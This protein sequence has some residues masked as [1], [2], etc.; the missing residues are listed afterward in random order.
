M[1]TRVE[2]RANR[3]WPASIARADASPDARRSACQVP[4]LVKTTRPMSDMV[5]RLGWTWRR[6]RGRS[7][8]RGDGSR[9]T[10]PI[11]DPEDG[12]GTIAGTQSPGCHQHHPGRRWSG[13]LTPRVGDD[14]R[15]GGMDRITDREATLDD[16]PAMASRGS[17]AAGTAGSPRPSCGFTSSASTTLSTPLH[18]VSR[19]WRSP[20]RPPSATSPGTYHPLRL[21]RRAA[22]APGRRRPP[23]RPGGDEAPAT[24]RGSGRPTGAPWVCERGVGQ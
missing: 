17:E 2:Q 5:L 15:A 13:P 1:G 4:D 9:W 21:R 3:V 11:I 18:L 7:G 12:P 10:Y 23:R 22:A 8:R 6:L 14:G 19:S 24:T 20:T 16:V